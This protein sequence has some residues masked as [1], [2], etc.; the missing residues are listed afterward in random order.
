MFVLG[1]DDQVQTELEEDTKL[2]SYPGG[3]GYRN[4]VWATLGHCKW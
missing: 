3:G 2:R 4:D 1:G